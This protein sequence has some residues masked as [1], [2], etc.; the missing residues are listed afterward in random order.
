I[1]NPQEHIRVMTLPGSYLDRFAEARGARRVPIQLDGASGTP[2][3]MSAPATRVFL[4]PA[5]LRL[6]AGSAQAPRGAAL[7]E[8]VLR[9][10]HGL[11][12][13]EGA[14][15]PASRQQRVRADPFIRLGAIVAARARA[16]KNQVALV[17]APDWR[18][19]EPWLEQLVEESLGKGGKGFCLFYGDQ[20]WS[21]LGTEPLVVGLGAGSTG[22]AALHLPRAESAAERLALVGALCLGFERTIA[23]YGY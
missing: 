3:R 16:G 1:A 10:I 5:A 13:V 23:T 12:G 18:G 19:F 21:T 7:L 20:D 17:A 15:D 22:D 8:P 9:L 2:G 4:L 14:L 11:A 6:L